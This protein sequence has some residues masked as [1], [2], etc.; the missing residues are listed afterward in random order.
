M[1]KYNCKR[2][3]KEF[4]Q[5]SHYDKHQNKKNPCQDNKR[6]IEEVIKNIIIN[7]KLILNNNKKIFN[8]NME[9]NKKINSYNLLEILNSILENKTYSDIAKN[10]NVAI[11]TVKRWNELKKVPKSYTF[12]LLKLSNIKIDYS[13]FSYKEKDQFFTPITTAKYCYSKFIEIIKKYGDSEKNYTFIEPSAG[14]GVFLNLLPKKRRIGFDIEPKNNEI[15]EQDYLD[16]KPLENKKYIVIGNPPFGL[17]GQLALKFINYSSKFADYVCFI[18]PQLFESD[19][20]GVPRK[21]VD[22]LNL[23]H[24]EKL[25]TC[26]E[27]PEG[28][29]IKVECIFQVWSKYH[30][31]NKYIID[32][33]I[34]KV[35]KIYSLS[36]GGTSSTTRNKKMFYKC[37]MY[38]PS[39]CFGKDN[40]KYYKNFDTLPGK[41]GYGIVFLKNKKENI[42]KFKEINW[43]NV[44]FL[45]TNSA[46]NIRSS[47]IVNQFTELK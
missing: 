42:K 4:S 13:N 18:L 46:Y 32:T 47:Q 38:L 45:S 29:N 17:R 25:D 37:D 19:G 26:F 31:N 23:I 28:E 12:E 22:G 14:N 7:K 8:N 33:K 9:K 27:S 24:S 43:S 41:K 34:S 10:I 1:S 40:M 2:C 6:L 30:I 20:K 36:D 3:L 16:W 5:K 11:G 21:R 44:A 15:K 35:I 39:T